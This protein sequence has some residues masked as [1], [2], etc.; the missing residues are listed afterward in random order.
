M[1]N[2]F[3]NL[4]VLLLFPFACFANFCSNLSHEE[5]I[6][7]G[8]FLDNKSQLN[9]IL[10]QQRN[11]NT[12]QDLLLSQF[13]TY[14]VSLANH[15]SEIYNE[16]AIIY[17]SCG[18]IHHQA[19]INSFCPSLKSSKLL[20]SIEL[21]NVSKQLILLSTH[22]GSGQEASIVSFIRN[23]TINQSF[24]NG[25]NSLISTCSSNI[26]E[27][28]DVCEV[29][30][31]SP[32]SNFLWKPVAHYTKNLVVLTNPYA[33]ISVNGETL[34]DT[35]SSNGRCTTA[36]G[37]KPGSEYGKNAV[38]VFNSARELI[39]IVVPDGSKRYDCKYG[40]LQSCGL[41]VYTETQAKRLTKKIKRL[42][43]KRKEATS[44]KRIR[45]LSS[46]IKLYKK[47]R[48]IARAEGMI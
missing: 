3:F 12:N 28:E 47:I 43:K 46:K 45:K 2:L 20:D 31:T 6:P 48:K 16:V 13:N 34:Q 23:T 15:G 41:G 21:F 11:Y 38:M 25:L 17:S 14:N 30:P 33:R 26:V 44:K 9:Q 5:M 4:L 10:F 40:T 37:P 27:E 1:K 18:T 24:I 29:S 35:G 36:R 32:I 39:I 7:I 8:H 42:Q 22:K 19:Y